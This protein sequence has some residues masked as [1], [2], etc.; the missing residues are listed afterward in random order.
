MENKRRT[1]RYDCAVP[2]ESKKGTA[3]DDS[4]T[5]DISSGGVGLISEKYIPIDTQMAVEIALT[6]ESDPF[7]TMG[8][9]KWIR[10]LPDL[11][12]YRVGMAFSESP[13]ALRSRINSHFK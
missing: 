2:V 9:V 4:L 11:H 1:S 10:Q 13:T 8:R 6:P 7:V 3:F 5:I 12:H